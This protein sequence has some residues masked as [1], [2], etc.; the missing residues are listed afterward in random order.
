M[1]FKPG[2]RV[3]SKNFGTLGTVDKYLTFID[4]FGFMLDGNA[5]KGYIVVYNARERLPG[6]SWDW[7][8]D[9]RKVTPLEKLL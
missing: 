3:I 4:H 1:S 8:D 2:D 7:A 6:Y 9:V 5:G